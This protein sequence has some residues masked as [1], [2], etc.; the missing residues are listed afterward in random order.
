MMWPLFNSP[1]HSFSGA[2]GVRP[3]R[4]EKGRTLTACLF[5]SV[6]ALFFSLLGSMAS[7]ASP[8]PD[9]TIHSLAIPSRFS[10]ADTEGCLGPESSLN[11]ACDYYQ[12]TVTNAG[13]QPASG[14]ITL[15]DE[16]PAGMKIGGRS[17]GEVVQF[18]LAENEPT[19][20]DHEAP[21][22]RPLYPLRNHQVTTL[23]QPEALPVSCEL[24]ESLQPDQRLVMK[25]YATV[26]PGAVSGTNIASVSEG[27]KLV[28]STSENDVISSTPPPFGARSLISDITGSSGASDVQ[29]GDHPYEFVTRIDLNTLIGK[30]PQGTAE[31]TPPG[32]GVRDVVLDLPLGFLGSATSTPKCAFAQLQSFPN[33]CPPNT[34]VGHITTEPTQA[35]VANSPLYNL[36]PEHGVAA[37]FGLVDFLSSP[38]VIDASVVP[39]AHGYVLRATA[40]E[41]PDAAWTDII[42][43]LYGNPAAKNGG[44]SAPSAQFTNPS[45]CSGEPL[46]T[47]LYMDSWEHPGALNADG[48]PNLSDP[49]WKEA[50]SESPPVTGCNALRFS[51]EAFSVKPETSA[52]DTPT[53][54]NFDLKIPQSETPETLATPPLRN[55][56]VT[57]PPGLTV[58]PSAAGGL[59]ACSEAQIGWLGGSVTDFTPDAPTCPEASKI[60]SV[61]VLTPLLANSLVGSVYLASQNENPF[62]ALLA[63]YIVID[64][65]ATGTIV[66][67][68]GNLTPNLQ[69]GQIT[70]VFDEN[71]QLPFSDLKLHFFGGP[72]GDLATPE[73]CG[74]YTTM[75][76]LEPW[77]APESGP[78]ATPSDSFQI[79]SGCVSGFAPALSAGTVSPQAGAFSP[80]TLSL[81]RN[82]SE[83]G[84]GGLTVS[85]PTG[86]LGRIAGIAECSDAQVAAAA[87]SSGAAE[88]SSP[89]CP[90][91][92]QLGTVT[93]ATGPGPDPFVV[94]GKAYLTGPYK[95]APY[96][97]A[98]IVPALAGPFDLGTVVIRQALY[99]DPNDAHV[100]DVS[101]PFPTILQGIPL[102]IKSVNVTLDRP[103]FTFN[104]T[105]CEP[106]AI[107]ATLT[108]IG[109]V[110]AAVSSRFQAAGCASLPFKPQFAVSTQG[111]TSKAAGASLDVKIAYPSSG[112]ANIA[113]VDLQF[114]KDLPSRLTTL[115]KACA[116]AQFD[117]NPA[118][119]P[120]ASDIATVVVHTPLLDVPLV[121]PA[122]FVSHGGAAFPDVELVLQ[123]EG[124]KLVVDGKTQ[125]KKG[126]TFSHFETVP[127]APFTSF[128]F[129]APEGPYSILTANGNLC[130]PTTTKTVRKR[131]TVRSNGHIKHV[132]KTVTS[133]VSEPLLMPTTITGQNG[134]VIKQTTKIAVTGCPKVG[135]AHNKQKANHHKKT[136]DKKK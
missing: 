82:D 87:A 108:S 72:R 52:A 104:P 27:G 107:N 121:G 125:I 128:E 35:A 80:F 95:G 31:A 117:T 93:T 38:H 132:T 105:S 42:T 70:G 96:G 36:I 118:G 7:A 59:Q 47:K 53:G 39:T 122:Y 99:I 103:E 83:E 10:S 32:H 89:S 77:S 28:T 16:L 71:P 33:S 13:S 63:G 69:T 40:R 102:R 11:S 110:P 74:T 136:G 6:T 106:K 60:G 56:S 119:C 73:G 45:D 30:N 98:V 88:Q 133:T 114:P 54:L 23:C 44:T 92:S 55:A 57:L 48:T 17:L 78:D 15:T 8:A 85:L 65:P 12:V 116:E 126:I 51:T 134:A 43:T 79:N 3:P 5:L 61:E 113:K 91:S 75:S 131:V 111:K 1:F 101:D 25:I 20:F 129:N 135:K 112:E 123:G 19:A 4:K 22:G 124:V 115:Q 84:L 94:G 86:L 81:S 127:D 97:V 130:A 120:A 66:K 41:V 68:A 37:E 50:V 90:S 21:E 64:D 58:D 49:N 76:D 109:G 46:T 18:S 26:E 14:P 9:L 62:H 67:I 24:P 29:A 2:D 34:I 100:T